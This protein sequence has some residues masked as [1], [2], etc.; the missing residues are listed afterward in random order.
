[1]QTIIIILILIL[2]EYIIEIKRDKRK[3]FVYYLK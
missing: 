3:L 2:I 1:M